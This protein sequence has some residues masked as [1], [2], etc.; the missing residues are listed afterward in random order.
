MW[1][2][3]KW[4]RWRRDMDVLITLMVCALCIGFILL[5]ALV[6]SGCGV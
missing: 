6:I 4:R 1:R 2:D 5:V 3:E